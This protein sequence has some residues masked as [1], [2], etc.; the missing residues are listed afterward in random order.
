M[1]DALKTGVAILSYTIPI[2]IVVG[3]SMLVASKLSTTEM[4]KLKAG[5]AEIQESLRE[6]KPKDVLET[7]SAEIQ[8]EREATRIDREEIKAAIRNDRWTYSDHARWVAKLKEANPDI[9]VPPPV[10]E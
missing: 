5:V 2:A 1:K 8:S 4:S 7:L 10:K 6:V 9:N 3:A